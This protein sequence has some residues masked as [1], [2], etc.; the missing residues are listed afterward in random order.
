VN[1]GALLDEVD[2]DDLSDAPS[3]DTDDPELDDLDFD[4]DFDFDLD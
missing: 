2:A 4:F 1:M 3:S